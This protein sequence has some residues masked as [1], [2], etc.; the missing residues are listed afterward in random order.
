MSTLL[1]NV[2]TGFTFPGPDNADNL[3]KLTEQFQKH[4]Q[5]AGA[6]KPE[7]EDD[8][9]VPELVAGATFEGVADEKP[10]S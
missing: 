6:I 9:D 10:S 4:A 7:N 8:D 1:T 5:S 2:F 3:R